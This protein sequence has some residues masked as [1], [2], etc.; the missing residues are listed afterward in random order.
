MVSTTV[1]VFQFLLVRLK[2]TKGKI[3]K[4]YVV[5]FQFLLVRLKETR[6]REVF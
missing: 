5:E 3:D 2:E 6:H 1:T 4:I